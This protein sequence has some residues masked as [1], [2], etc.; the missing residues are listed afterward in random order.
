MIK[1]SSLLMVL[2][3]FLL[4][5]CQANT[6]NEKNT[7]NQKQASQP[8][9]EPVV[10]LEI[11][12]KAPEL[13][14]NNPDGEPIALSSLEGKIVLI[15]FWA[16]WCPPCRRENPYIVGVYDKFKDADFKNGEGFTIYSVSLDR[17][18]D[19][20]VKAIE[21]DNL[22]WE[23]HVSDLKYWNSEAAK[24]YNVRGIPTNYL[25]DGDGII[26]AKALRGEQ[27]AEELSEHLK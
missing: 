13:V 9:S 7:E 1:Q 21:D 19:A 4:V 24:I 3:S 18:K 25:I 20:W 2:M 22:N 6:P 10:G 5:T 16:A 12:N 14:F 8:T 15:D 27:L 23:Y 11:G 26:V 17:T